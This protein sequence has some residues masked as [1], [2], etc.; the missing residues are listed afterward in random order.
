[1]SNIENIKIIRKIEDINEDCWCRLTEENF[2]NLKKL[3]FELGFETFEGYEKNSVFE[4][5]YIFYIDSQ[6]KLIFWDSSKKAVNVPEIKFELGEEEKSESKNSLEQCGF[7]NPNGY[8]IEI[9]KVYENNGQKEYVGVIVF[10][11]DIIPMKWDYEGK[12]LTDDWNFNLEHIE[13]KQR[14]YTK[15]NNEGFLPKQKFK[16]SWTRDMS[17]SL[18]STGWR[19]ATNEEIEKFKN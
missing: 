1:M 10:E 2:N 9:L 7:K 4:E 18:E 11:G 5:E 6:C 15:P 13:Y 8:D 14:L 17:S 19:L 16:V 12:S 3:G